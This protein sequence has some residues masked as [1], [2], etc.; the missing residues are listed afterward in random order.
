VTLERKERCIFDA[1]FNLWVNL[2]LQ[3][4][5]SSPEGLVGP[6]AQATIEGLVRKMRGMQPRVAEERSRRKQTHGAVTDRGGSLICSLPQVRMRSLPPSGV[7]PSLRCLPVSVKVVKHKPC[8]RSWGTT[9]AN[10]Q[11]R[12]LLTTRGRLCSWTGGIWRVW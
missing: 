10:I 4:K 6:S 7:H 11:Q 9:T 3:L 1:T 8:R 5:H 2:C 12:F